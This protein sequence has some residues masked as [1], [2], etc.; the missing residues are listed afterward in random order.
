MWVWDVL[1]LDEAVAAKESSALCPEVSGGAG[2]DSLVFLSR[3]AYSSMCRKIIVR[4]P[5][6]LAKATE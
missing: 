4:A 2:N 3:C 5:P 1:L 6:D